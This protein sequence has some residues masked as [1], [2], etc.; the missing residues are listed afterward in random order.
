MC[1]VFIFVLN[2]LTQ[3][4]TPRLKPKGFPS[5]KNMN[6]IEAPFDY[7]I[8]PKE[9]TVFFGGSITGAKDWQKNLF[10]HIFVKNVKIGI[11]VFNPRRQNFNIA[12]QSESE[13][14]ISWEHK[15]LNLSKTLVFYFAEETLGPITLFELGGALERN[16]HIGGTPQNILVYCEPEYKRKFDVKYQ[17]KLVQETYSNKQ[18]GGGA[19]PDFVTFYED[20]DKFVDG[21][22]EKLNLF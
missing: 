4:T 1:G 7:E 17:I 18:L 12:N 10:Y 21:L 15:Y 9:N 14:Q 13:I 8:S 6:Y 16:L 19:Y 11:I 20:Y 22:V 2:L 3:S 5:S